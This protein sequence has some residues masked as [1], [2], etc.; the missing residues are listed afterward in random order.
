MVAGVIGEHD[1]RLRAQPQVAALVFEEVGLHPDPREIG[2]GEQVHPRLHLLPLEDLLAG[3]VAGDGGGQGDRALGGAGLLQAG[4]GARGHVEQLQASAGGGQ[5]VL[6]PPAHLGQGGLGEARRGLARP[7]ELLLRG[8]QLG[9]VERQQRLAGLHELA[10]RTDVELF[11]PAGDL[12]LHAA[13]AGLV[14]HHDPGGA[15]GAGERAPLGH[16]RLHPGEPHP[17]PRDLDRRMPRDPAGGGAPQL[18]GVDG[19][20]VHAHLVLGRHRRGDGRIHGMTIEED[21]AS[22]RLSLRGGGGL[23]FLLLF[24]GHQTHATDRAVAGLVRVVVRV[25]RAVVLLGGLLAPPVAGEGGGEERGHEQDDRGLE[26]DLELHGWP[27]VNA[28]SP[29][30]AT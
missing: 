13:D 27:P 10:G 7:Q 21:L 19:H 29:A 11:D 17:L 30:Q 8:E 3:D 20:V 24:D 26:E 25:H 28:S 18:I 2:D 22:G 9:G 6:T 16:G 4:D 1:E 14:R 5:Q 15:G 23:L 12:G